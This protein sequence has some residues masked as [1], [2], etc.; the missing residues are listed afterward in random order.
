M[1]ANTRRTRR[2]G[3]AVIHFD[4]L[5]LEARIWGDVR[6]TGRVLRYIKNRT[7]TKGN[8][9]PMRYYITHNGV[10]YIRSAEKFFKVEK[11]QGSVI[12]VS[13]WKE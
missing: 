13:K 12:S 3:S 5:I 11:M 9:R 4:E 1:A 10:Y 7:N 6:T 8:K 2:K